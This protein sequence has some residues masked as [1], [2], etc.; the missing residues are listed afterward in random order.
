MLKKS[1]L[2]ITSIITLS[3]CLQT[4]YADESNNVKFKSLS[5]YQHMIEHLAYHSN[6]GITSLSYEGV[7][8]TKTG[9]FY[10]FGSLFFFDSPGIPNESKITALGA[11]RDFLAAATDSGTVYKWTQQSYQWQK[12]GNPLNEY[13][14]TISNISSDDSMIYLGTKSGKIY[15]LKNNTW[16]KLGNFHSMVT[17]FAYDENLGVLYFG[18]K[19]GKT[20]LYDK[21]EHIKKFTPIFGMKHPGKIIGLIVNPNNHY[22]MATTESKDVY[23][24]APADRYWRN[25]GKVNNEE[26]TV[27]IQ[28]IAPGETNIIFA[29]TK[30]GHVYKGDITG[31]NWSD[32]SYPN[33]GASIVGMASPN[34][35]PDEELPLT[36]MDTSQKIYQYDMY[37]NKWVFVKQVE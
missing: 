26:V 1:L 18:L 12:I 33:G 13:I 9:N 4:I 11:N 14:T 19:N 8:S 3:C 22:I 37:Q 23:L 28:D 21:N 25:V 30:S 24:K 36:V 16:V 6:E 10:K 20:F 27:L 17:S 34:Q 2:Q 35:D 32:I 7:L 15:T 5:N 29:G 31:K